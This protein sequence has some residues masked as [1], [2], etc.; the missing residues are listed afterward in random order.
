MLTSCC[1]STAVFCC[2]MLSCSC[3]SLLPPSC[4]SE[5]ASAGYLLQVSLFLPA[6]ERAAGTNQSSTTW[7][8]QT[9]DDCICCWCWLASLLCWCCCD[10]SEM[11]FINT[12]MSWKVSAESEGAA[13]WLIAVCTMVTCM[14]VLMPCMTL[15]L[16]LVLLD[17]CTCLGPL[18]STSQAHLRA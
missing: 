12:T 3:I 6:K 18:V 16:L 14:Y 4:T 8:T 9:Q 17:R 1:Q 7:S 13:A 15:L 10:L 5:S 2:S 11:V